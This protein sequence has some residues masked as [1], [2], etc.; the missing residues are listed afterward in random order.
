MPIIGVSR[1]EDAD[2]RFK[3]LG[4]LKKGAPKSSR[5]QDLDYFRFDAPNADVLQ[6]FI[7]AYG[8]EPDRL[9]IYLP[10]ATMEEN[11]TSWREAYGQNG[12]CKIRCD[13]DYWTDWIEGARHYHGHKQCVFDCKDTENKCPGCA[14]K[15][16]GRLTIIL[17]QLWHAGYIGLVTLE[18]H[19]WNDIATIAGKLVQWEPL[20]GKAFVI[21]REDTR[22]GAPINGKRAAIEK[23][24]IKIE[25]TDEE[26]LLD[27][28]AARRTARAALV[29]VIPEDATD[30]EEFDGELVYE[31]YT[32]P[33]PDFHGAPMDELAYDD[34]LPG[35][36]EYIAEAIK[37]QPPVQKVGRDVKELLT[38]KPIPE[39]PDFSKWRDNEW[40]R[41]YS[42][43]RLNLAFTSDKH[44][45]NALKQ[46]FT[47][48]ETAMPAYADAWAL[49]VQH[50]Q[51]AGRLA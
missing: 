9:E 15:P 27:F 16:V 41:F 10:Y 45:E 6:A 11:F 42:L 30:E 12:L 20:Q 32:E 5:P 18:T 33:T 28:Q 38:P 37:A 29:D 47:E 51:E 22:I 21:W 7:A 17:P 13:G 26:L 46:I 14:L 4:K 35:D 40:A 8:N 19:S 24:L 36:D 48:W 50:Q 49:M 34:L 39:T 2:P 23:S 43:A 3:S 44:A 25:R 31:D 1:R